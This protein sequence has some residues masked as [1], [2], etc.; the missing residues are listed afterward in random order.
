MKARIVKI[1]GFSAHADREG[2]LAWLSDIHV[3]P[4]CVFVTHGEETG[5]ISFARFLT[6]KTGWPTKVPQYQETVILT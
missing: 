6:G 1:D 5:A 2:L 3:P 4:R